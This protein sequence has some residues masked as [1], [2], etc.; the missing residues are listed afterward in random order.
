MSLLSQFFPSGSSA[1]GSKTKVNMLL[2]SGGGGGGS[3]GPDPCVPAPIRGTACERGGGGGGGGAGTAYRFD[4]FYIA[5]NSTISVTIGS[6]GNSDSDGGNS[7]ICICNQDL[8]IA[9]GGKSGASP[10]V[11]YSSPSVFNDIYSALSFVTCGLGGGGRGSVNISSPAPCVY[12]SNC[13]AINTNGPGFRWCGPSGDLSYIPNPL[14]Q[15]CIC[16]EAVRAITS[17]PCGKISRGVY[18]SPYLSRGGCDFGGFGFFGVGASGAGGVG[19]GRESCSSCLSPALPSPTY[20]PIAPFA[21]PVASSGGCGIYSSI[22][23]TCVE[24]AAGGGGGGG[25]TIYPPGAVPLISAPNYC[26]IFGTSGGSSTTGGCGGV[27]LLVCTPYG[28]VVFNATAGCNA[29]ANLG[30]GGGGAG[31]MPCGCTL[32]GGNGGS[33]VFVIQYP[34]VIPAAPAFP[35]ACDCS[36]STPGFRTYKFN[37]PGSITLP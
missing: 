9:M 36:P 15:N 8:F 13:N 22:T 7:C 37:G 25:S 21:I 29:T 34:T 33:G 14:S 31:F 16:N 2:V 10:T 27:G 28:S 30:G 4:E 35:G 32:S 19:S 3:T 1:G 12:S 6:G 26:S 5:N 18:F 24:Y 11:I 17:T 20:T 23:G